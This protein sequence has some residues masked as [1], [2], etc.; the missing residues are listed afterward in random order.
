MH[1]HRHCFTATLM[2]ETH[3]T[4]L[5]FCTGL[6]EVRLT[7]PG[8]EQPAQ[9]ALCDSTQCGITLTMPINTTAFDRTKQTVSVCVC[10]CVCL[11]GL[12]V[13]GEMIMAV[14]MRGRV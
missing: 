9:Q 6:L 7:Y 5:V 1:M 3:L 8:T 2:H 10:V 12:W 14:C 4:F 13:K 11:R